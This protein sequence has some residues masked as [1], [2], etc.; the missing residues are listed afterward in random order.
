M[1]EVKSLFPD[2]ANYLK[3]ESLS[4]CPDEH[5]KMRT[6]QTLKEII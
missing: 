6:I 2:G 1:E 5:E 4:S 3:A